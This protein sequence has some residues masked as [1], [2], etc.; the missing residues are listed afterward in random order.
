MNYGIYG[1]LLWDSPWVIMIYTM[2]KVMC[3]IAMEA[4]AHRNAYVFSKY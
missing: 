2:E 1:D 3:S 4:M